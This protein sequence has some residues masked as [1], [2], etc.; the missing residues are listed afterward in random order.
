LAEYLRR[1][2]I[3]LASFLFLLG[4]VGVTGL[5]T[6]RLPERLQRLVQSSSFLLLAAALLLQSGG[7][8]F[9]SGRKRFES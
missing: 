2:E 6:A 7:H 4:I 3:V 9:G 8:F 1:P 5:L